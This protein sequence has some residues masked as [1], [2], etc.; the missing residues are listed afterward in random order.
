[1]TTTRPVR[2]PAAQRRHQLLDVAREQ[3][4]ARGFHQT[5]MDEIADV[6]GVTKPVLYQHFASKRELYLELLQQV[7]GELSDALASAAAAQPTPFARLLSGFRAYFAF[8]SE[9]TSAF[10]LL[11]GGGAQRTPE[12][13]DAIQAVEERLATVIAGFID[14]DIRPDHRRLLGFAIVGAAEVASRQWVIRAAPGV[15]LDPAEGDRLARWLADVLFAGLRGLP[16]RT[17]A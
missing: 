6:A 9:R 15:P 3:F 4:A 13:A 2:L 8:V 1:M 14:A 5:S 11:F 7:G 12:F 10:E 17:G 16:G